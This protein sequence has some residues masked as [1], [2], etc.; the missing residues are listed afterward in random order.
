MKPFYISFLLLAIQVSSVLFFDVLIAHFFSL[1]NNMI[2]YG[3]MVCLSIH[4]WKDILVAF[5]FWQFLMYFL[6]FYHT[7]NILS[8]IMV[9]FIQV[10]SASAFSTLLDDI[11]LDSSA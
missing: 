3:H 2:F 10:S 7:E 4:P 8:A 1:M 11:F 6:T 5:C 9:F